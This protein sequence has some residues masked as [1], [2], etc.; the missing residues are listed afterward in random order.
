MIKKKTKR[1]VVS[2]LC[3]LAVAFGVAAIGWQ[4]GKM[5][6]TSPVKIVILHTNDTHSQVEPIAA[7]AKNE[8]RG[9]YA[10]RM[11]LIKQFRNEEPELLLLDAGDF[12]QGT[13]YFNFYNGRVEVD[14]L[15]RMKYDVVT[16]GNHEFDNGVD[17]LAA[18]LSKARF[19]VVCANYQVKG[20]PLEGIVKPYVILR[21]KGVKI[22]VLGVGVR[23]DGLIA[24]QNFA[25]LRW[26]DPLPVANEVADFLR[27][28]KHCDLVVCLSH[29]GTDPNGSPVCDTWLAEN[30]RNIDVIIGGHT[31]KVVEN[32][33]LTNLDGHDVILE[34]M[35]KSGIN[36]GRIVVELDAKR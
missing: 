15:N 14:A 19:A 30:T 16:L 24:P 10:R 23:P 26:E 12:S 22:G 2:V 11:G 28:E 3:A 17:T 1:A 7:G 5:E 36:L 35:G 32:R 4:R 6:V 21:R 29:L 18:V 31:H 33:H 34:Q 27:N 9:G 20:T 13:P 8:G 25:P